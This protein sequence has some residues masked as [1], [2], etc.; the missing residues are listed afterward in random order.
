MFHCF[1]GES[2]NLILVSVVLSLWQA[3]P[4]GRLY[5]QTMREPVLGLVTRG[6]LVRVMPPKLAC[7][8]CMFLLLV[9]CSAANNNNVINNNNNNNYKYNG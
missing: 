8:I 7:V 2:A 9:S 6:W 3:P 5:A 4:R 1:F